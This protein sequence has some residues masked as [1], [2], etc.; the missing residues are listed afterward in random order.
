MIF[1]YRA[2]DPLGRAVEGELEARDQARAFEELRGRALTP[3]TVSP[4][5]ES[6][7]DRRR[8]SLRPADKTLEADGDFLR[9]KDETE[10]A[11]QPPP[12][13]PA[14][15]EVETEEEPEESA[16]VPARKSVGWGNAI[17]LFFL[18]IYFLAK[19]CS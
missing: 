7:A 6:P 11:V 18:V 8:R 10:R 4:V 13:I 15:P 14:T 3:I 19:A 9:S 5:G 16:G 17:W 12:V 1:R 2:R